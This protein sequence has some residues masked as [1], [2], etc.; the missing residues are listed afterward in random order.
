[1]STVI[2]IW[3]LVTISVVLAVGTGS[4]MLMFERFGGSPTTG[5]D[6]FSRIIAHQMSNIRDIDD[7]DSRMKN[8]AKNHAKLAKE[9]LK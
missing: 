4:A 9:N 6:D 7:L 3:L 5:G 8:W 1:M 2:A